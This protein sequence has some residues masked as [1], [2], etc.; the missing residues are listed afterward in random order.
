MRVPIHFTGSHRIRADWVQPDTVNG[1]LLRYE[2]YASSVVGQLG[3]L[4]LNDTVL[5]DR[6]FTMQ[7]LLAGTTYYVTLLVSLPETLYKVSS[8]SEIQEKSLNLNKCASVL[9]KT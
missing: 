1:N 4:M 7:N 9:E 5:G 3:E 2:L 6:H 8:G